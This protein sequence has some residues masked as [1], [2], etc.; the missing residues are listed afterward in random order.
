MNG[1]SLPQ[2]AQLSHQVKS[3]ESHTQILAAGWEE[4]LARL[5]EDLEDRDGQ[6]SSLQSLSQTAESAQGEVGA[7]Q[8]SVTHLTEER[9]AL[10]DELQEVKGQ[11]GE[12]EEQERAFADHL[13]ADQQATSDLSRERALLAIQL[14]EAGAELD[15]LRPKQGQVKS[16]EANI[17]ALQARIEEQEQELTKK[18]DRND[19]T[20]E[21]LAAVHSELTELKVRLDTSTG[22][23]GD[24]V[25]STHPSHVT[26][27][28]H[29][30]TQ[31]DLPLSSQ[32][33]LGR[34]QF[35]DET[36][37]LTPETEHQLMTLQ[38][39]VESLKRE[40]DETKL[41]LTD[42]ESRV[43]AL[44]QQQQ[45]LGRKMVYQEAQ[46]SKTQT[47]LEKE[48][49]ALKDK[50]QSL[51]AQVSTTLAQTRPLGQNLSLAETMS[52]EAQES[53]VT[54]LALCTQALQKAELANALLVDEVHQLQAQREDI[55]KAL[56]ETQHELMCVKEAHA[57]LGLEHN[58][59]KRR[60]SSVEENI[61][62]NAALARD[63][64]RD[65]E[66]SV[67]VLQSEKDGA[68]AEHQKTLR[69]LEALQDV[70]DSLSSK[71]ADSMLQLDL[72]KHAAAKAAAESAAEM[73]MLTQR[74][75]TAEFMVAQR[76]NIQAI[77]VK[78]VLTL[79]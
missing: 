6:I 10:R 1:I 45:M 32:D 59:A 56:Q 38:A 37:A 50:N 75:K 7:L 61:V 54:Q 20:M 27:P 8:Q 63:T 78:Q 41:D 16:L 39:Q 40:R 64:S 15:M 46:T 71:F 74:V 12:M 66:T 53:S 60:L 35:P 48:L 3:M 31:K 51:S 73:K 43:A 17:Q 52:L 62:A 22:R 26:H 77:F 65:F 49:Q 25:T 55:S 69:Q 36:A 68:R 58:T 11:L 24:Y 30:H 47:L 19:A 67:S 57:T 5:R 44:Q 29:T 23:L 28:P 21:E 42:A 76:D 79:P 9:D 4:K 13:V 18:E 34:P 33:S 72:T 70:Y 2:V 14:S